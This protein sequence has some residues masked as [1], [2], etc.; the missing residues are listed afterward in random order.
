MGFS[1]GTGSQYGRPFVYTRFHTRRTYRPA[2]PFPLSDTL[3]SSL[4]SGQFRAF[5][6]PAASFL[7]GARFFS[8]TFA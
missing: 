5:L 3:A 4:Y 1:G 2:Y 7:N 6:S 8:P